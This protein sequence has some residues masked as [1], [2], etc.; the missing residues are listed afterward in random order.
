MDAGD[1]C[2]AEVRITVI[3]LVV[4]PAALTELKD[5]IKCRSHVSMYARMLSSY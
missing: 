1:E 4:V 5:R 2:N 3:A